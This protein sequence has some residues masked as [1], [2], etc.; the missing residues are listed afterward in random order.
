MKKR[1]PWGDQR[2]RTFQREGAAGAA[3]E[4]RTGRKRGHEEGESDRGRIREEF[5]VH[6][7]DLLLYSKDTGEI[8]DFKGSGNQEGLP[9]GGV[10]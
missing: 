8:E 10:A 3:G 9:E 1:Q 6:H 4:S 5:V 2:E 7:K